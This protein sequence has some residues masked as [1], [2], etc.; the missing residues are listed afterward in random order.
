MNMAYLIC[1][2]AD[3]RFFTIGYTVFHD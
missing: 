3:V 2:G 1:M